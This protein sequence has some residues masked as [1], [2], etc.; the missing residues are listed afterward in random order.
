M[1]KEQLKINQK[2]E[3]RTILK[4]ESKTMS[5]NERSISGCEGEI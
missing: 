1:K 3:S 4:S 5:N 2:M